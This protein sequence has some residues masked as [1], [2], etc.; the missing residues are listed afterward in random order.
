MKYQPDFKNLCAY[1]A[2]YDAADPSPTLH[3]LRTLQMDLFRK[4]ENG[5]APH[6][7]WDQVLEEI[8]FQ[9]RWFKA[10]HCNV[11]ED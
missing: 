4:F 6:E 7:N 8:E 9:I 10:Y 2:G 1:N 5:L 11:R 3:N